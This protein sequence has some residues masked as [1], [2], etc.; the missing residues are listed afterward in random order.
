MATKPVVIT[1]VVGLE[2]IIIKLAKKA[3][4]ISIEG[5]KITVTKRLSQESIKNSISKLGP[6]GQLKNQPLFV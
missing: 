5:Q 2:R 1:A 3:T 4:M 6:C